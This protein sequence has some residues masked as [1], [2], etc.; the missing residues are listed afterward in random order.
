MLGGYAGDDIRLQYD[1]SGF[2][3]K[4][5]AV[6]FGVP[7]AKI[8]LPRDI[9]AFRGYMPA[10][11]TVEESIAAW[12][13]LQQ[14]ENVAASVSSIAV[15]EWVPRIRKIYRVLPIKCGEFIAVNAD[16]RIGMRI[17]Q[18]VAWMLSFADPLGLGFFG[19]PLQRVRQKR[20]PQWQKWVIDKPLITLAGRR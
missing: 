1:I 13:F 20:T 5:R 12:L 19:K 10:R 17:Q 7:R 9:P 18:H 8:L 6:K 2:Y 16:V 14:P 15:A 11:D 4:S 3:M